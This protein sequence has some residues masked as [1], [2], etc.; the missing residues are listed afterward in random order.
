T[1]IF[2]GLRSSELRGLPWDAVDFEKK[3]IRVYQRADRYGKIGRP[4]S[5]AGERE[6]PMTPMVANT[7][8][9]WKLQCPKGELGLVFPTSK[10]EVEGHSYMCHAGIEASWKR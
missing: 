8:R 5:D 7:L 6:V 4:K 1:A 10:G 9:E 2:T 3:V